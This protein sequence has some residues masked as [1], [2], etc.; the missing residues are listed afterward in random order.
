MAKQIVLTLTPDQADILGY[1]LNVAKREVGRRA[2]LIF[3]KGASFDTKRGHLDRMARIEALA[4]ELDAA[5]EV[6]AVQVDINS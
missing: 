4:W 3:G 1:A 2:D 5:P 6:D